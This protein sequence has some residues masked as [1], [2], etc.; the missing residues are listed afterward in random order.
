MIVLNIIIWLLLGVLSPFFFLAYDIKDEEYDFD[1]FMEYTHNLSFEMVLWLT[2]LGPFSYL[3]FLICIFAIYLQDHNFK[4]KFYKK[5][6]DLLYKITHI[7][8]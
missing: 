7:F 4:Q 5:L 2:I 1:E 8:N 3:F 6:Y